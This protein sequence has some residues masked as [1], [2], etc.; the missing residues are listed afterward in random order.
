M[1]AWFSSPR[2][3]SCVSSS[4]KEL[5]LSPVARVA[6]GERSLSAWVRWRNQ[7]PKTRTSTM[8]THKFVGLDVHSDTTMIAV[9]EGERSG[10]GA[11]SAK[12][13]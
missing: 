1:F 4:G 8:Q 13:A 10:D 11:R 6:P 3:Y 5:C 12:M 7:P 2:H 9:A